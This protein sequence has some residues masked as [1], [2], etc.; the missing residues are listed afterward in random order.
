MQKYAFCLV[1]HMMSDSYPFCSEMD[2][3]PF[4]KGVSG[5]PSGLLQS[6]LILSG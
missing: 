3:R 6:L 1:I 5:F 4:Q 2:A